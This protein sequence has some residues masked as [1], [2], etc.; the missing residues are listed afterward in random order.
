MNFNEVIKQAGDFQKK[1]EAMKQ[2]MYNME[3]EGKAGGGLVNVTLKGDGK[4]KFLK[5]DE[6][7]C[8]PSEKEVLED[9]IVAAFNDAKEKHEKDSQARMGSLMGGFLPGFKL[10]F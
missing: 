5:L 4:I 6:S 3:F 10:P 8:N 2:E 7:L 1:M 9:L